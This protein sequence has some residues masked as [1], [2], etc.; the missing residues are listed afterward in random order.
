MPAWIGWGMCQVFNQGRV[1]STRD[2]RWRPT[3][4]AYP[5][6]L[7][8]H[9]CLL[10]LLL[11]FTALSPVPLWLGVQLCRPHFSTPPLLPLALYYSTPYLSPPLD[12]P[13]TLSFYWIVLSIP[14]SPYSGLSL[15]YI[16]SGYTSFLL[17]VFFQYNPQL[18]DSLRHRLFVI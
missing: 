2:N 17:S 3:P 14:V 1:E 4:S 18:V 9:R 6:H 11:A 12:L 8:Y 16:L 7:A 10:H 5:L 13:S 15:I